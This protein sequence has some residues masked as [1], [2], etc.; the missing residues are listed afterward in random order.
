MIKRCGWTVLCLTTRPSPARYG[1]TCQELP[2]TGIAQR[3]IGVHKP[4][5]HDKVVLQKS[6][7]GSLWM[8]GTVCFLC[9]V[10]ALL[11]PFETRGREMPQTE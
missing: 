1:R 3:V 5:Y 7:V 10:A 4:P 2:S 11:L 6:L 8:Y 9:S